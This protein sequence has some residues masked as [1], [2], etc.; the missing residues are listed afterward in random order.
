MR[1][2]LKGVRQL[3]RKAQTVMAPMRAKLIE[4]NL[5]EYCNSRM[6]DFILQEKAGE[7]D[8]KPLHSV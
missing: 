6:M 2:Q 5:E 8:P 1:N 4:S 3:P 7:F